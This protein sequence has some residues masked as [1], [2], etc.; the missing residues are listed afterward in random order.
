MSRYWISGVSSTSTLSSAAG[1]AT[2][3]HPDVTVRVVFVDYLTGKTLTA[4]TVVKA[5]LPPAGGESGPAQSAPA[6][7]PAAGESR[8]LPPEA[9]CLLPVSLLS[10]VRRT[11]PPKERV[12]VRRGERA[13]E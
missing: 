6:A 11:G 2:A 1:R 7:R 13:W 10:L 5:N 8:G 3:D 4:Q 9:C 12:P